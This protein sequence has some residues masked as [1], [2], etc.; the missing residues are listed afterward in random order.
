MAEILRVHN[1]SSIVMI[2]QLSGLSVT[3]HYKTEKA[4]ILYVH[5]KSIKILSVTSFFL[6]FSD[7]NLIVAQLLTFTYT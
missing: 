6:I 7:P 1:E 5:V 2:I 3:I 4:E